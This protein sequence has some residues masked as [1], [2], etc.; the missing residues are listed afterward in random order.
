MSFMTFVASRISGAASSVVGRGATA[1]AAV[2]SAVRGGTGG[3]VTGAGGGGDASRTA[4]RQVDEVVNILSP[5]PLAQSDNP[6]S[7]EELRA[8]GEAA[9]VAKRAWR[10]R[11]A[12][13]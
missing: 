4:E 5:G 11:T 13:G 8:A 9:R 1:A 10:D 2:A 12:R 7:Q 3:A 6:P